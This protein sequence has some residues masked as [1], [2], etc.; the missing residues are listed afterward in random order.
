MLAKILRTRRTRPVSVPLVAIVAGAIALAT[1]VALDAAEAAPPGMC[2]A[3][4]VVAPALPAVVNISV[5]QV[6]TK[7]GADGSAKEHLEINDGSGVI[8]DPSGLIVTNR[9]VIQSA[10]VIRVAFNDHSEVPAQLIQASVLVD[11]ALLKV[12]SAKPLPA[13]RFADSDALRVGQPVIAVGNPFGIGTS[14]TTGV[15]SALNRDFMRSPVDNLIQTDAAINPGN[16]GGPLLDCAGDIVGI[17]TALASNNKALGSIGIGFAIPSNVVNYVAGRLRRPETDAPD[18]FGLQLQDMTPSMA[19]ALHRHNVGGAVVT[20]ADRDSPAARVFLA[21]G[22]I[23][24]A[25]DGQELSDS[26]AILRE[27]VTKPPGEP[28][29]LSVSRAGTTKN[30]TIVGQQ[31]PHLA[32][33]RKEILADAEAVARA[34]AQGTGMLLTEITPESRQHFGLGDDAGVLI[35][36][37]EEG[38]QAESAG[39][40]SGD[41]IERIGDKA[42]TTPEQVRQDLKLADHEGQELIA[43]L[44]HGKTN[45][46]WVA[47]CVGRVNVAALMFAPSQSSAIGAA[48]SSPRPRD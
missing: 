4:G 45:T 38:S 21:P 13:L 36:E 37:V 43:I 6:V 47:L 11:L 33:L 40:K 24:T 31:W 25:V 35:Y 39:L 26:R 8:I 3:A 30:V 28:A 23:I 46:R 1:T 34:Q 20:A 12:E 27:L 14:V 22:D 29:V 15:V 18:W 41:V 2:D 19:A 44:V 7:T 10:A 42:A 17:D 5:I 9:H 48:A 32:M 16:S